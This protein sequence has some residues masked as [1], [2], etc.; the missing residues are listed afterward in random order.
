VFEK[1]RCHFVHYVGS[2]SGSAPNGDVGT[3]ESTQDARNDESILDALSPR[4]G[5]VSPM[6][7]EDY[8]AAM[9]EYD[10]EHTAV[11]K[12]PTTQQVLATMTEL[13][14]NGDTANQRN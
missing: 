11:D 8:E 13:V 12:P 9:K 10:E 2:T 5:D 6:N 4:L 7:S 3:N 14:D 1:Q